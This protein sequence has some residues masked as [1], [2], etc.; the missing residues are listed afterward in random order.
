LLLL[1]RPIVDRRPVRPFRESTK[2]GADLPDASPGLQIRPVGSV[3]FQDHPGTPC[4]SDIICGLLVKTKKGTGS[5]T[6]PLN[7]FCHF[8]FGLLSGLRHWENRNK[9]TAFKALV[10]GHSTVGGCKDG[11]IFAQTNAFARPKLGAALT[12]DD[13][14]CDGRLATIQF[15]AKAA[16]G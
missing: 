5:I 2:I 3:S 8:G 14:A 11:V 16:T 9:G 12:Y 15:H 7:I 1:K 4:P 10:E 6:D 13:V